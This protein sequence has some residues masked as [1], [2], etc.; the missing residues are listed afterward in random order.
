MCHHNLRH[1]S[2]R[3][4]LWLQGLPSLKQTRNRAGV[5]ILK[6]PAI[7]TSNTAFAQLRAKLLR[8]I[9]MVAPVALSVAELWVELVMM[10]IDAA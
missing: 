4:H 3:N 5:I 9:W 1:R 8:I 6:T 10:V 7:G 2:I